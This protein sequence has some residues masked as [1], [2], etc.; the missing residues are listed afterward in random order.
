VLLRDLFVRVESSGEVSLFVYDN[1]TF[2]IESF[3]PENVDVQI[4]LDP[5]FTRIQDVTSAQEFSGKVG[6]S[7]GFGFFGAG[8]DKRMMIPM[9]IKPHSY[10]VFS[11]LQ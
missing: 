9:Q 7:G 6:V 1:D 3:L 4:S 8:S 5:R 2:I 10:R 11:A